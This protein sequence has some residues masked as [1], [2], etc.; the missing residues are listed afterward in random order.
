MLS[1]QMLAVINFMISKKRE[2]IVFSF[3]FSKNQ[4]KKEA[5]H[6]AIVTCFSYN[7]NVG[8][9]KNIILLLIKIKKK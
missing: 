8:I 4:N 5:R 2:V 1:F 7:L 3:L 9:Y 6:H